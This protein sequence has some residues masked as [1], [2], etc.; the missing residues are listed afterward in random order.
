MRKL[1][2]LKSGETGKIKT[3]EANPSLRQRLLE[4]GFTP[5]TE[6]EVEQF[7]PLADPVIFKILGYHISLRKTEAATIILEN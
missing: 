6:V 2:E 4:M 7:A 5:G 3:I 1:S